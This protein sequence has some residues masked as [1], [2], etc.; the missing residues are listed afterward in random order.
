[1]TPFFSPFRQPMPLT[2]AMMPQSTV[3]RTF[4]ASSTNS[5][6]SPNLNVSRTANV[7]QTVR[8]NFPTTLTPLPLTAA[9]TPHPTATPTLQD[10]S[11]K[12]LPSPTL[13]VSRTAN[14]T[15]TVQANSP[16]TLTPHLNPLQVVAHRDAAAVRAEVRRELLLSGAAS[17]LLGT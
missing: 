9:T 2:A 12:P 14:V 1:P 16:A 15:Q 6:S 10:G 5:L 8:A 7:T 13:N 17:T 4:Q 11:P 3:S